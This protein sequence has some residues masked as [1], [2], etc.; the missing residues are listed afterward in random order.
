MAGV[1]DAAVYIGTPEPEVP[2][3]GGNAPSGLPPGPGVGGGRSGPRLEGMVP[4]TE[5]GE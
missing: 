4:S 2:D 3:P 1:P 5:S